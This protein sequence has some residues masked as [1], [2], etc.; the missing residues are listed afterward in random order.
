MVRCRRWHLE[1]A[2]TRATGMH[3]LPWRCQVNLSRSENPKQ[4][5]AIT[6]RPLHSA[7]RSPPRLERFAA[8]I[9]RPDGVER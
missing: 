6:L 9:A 4:D 7:I 2:K 1:R 3:A 8:L 5:G